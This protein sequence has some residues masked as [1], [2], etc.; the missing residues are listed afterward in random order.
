MLNEGCLRQLH[1]FFADFAAGARLRLDLSSLTVP[2]AE[3]VDGS[4]GPGV[5]LFTLDPY[6]VIK[7]KNRTNNVFAA[8]VNFSNFSMHMERSEYST[9]EGQQENTRTSSEKSFTLLTFLISNKNKLLTTK[10]K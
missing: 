6:M 3:Q 8:L 10:E 1:D 7:D 2:D 4:L 9:N 5:I